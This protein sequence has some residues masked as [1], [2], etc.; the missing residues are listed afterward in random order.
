MVGYEDA[1]RL[2]AALTATD[3]AWPVSDQPA[4]PPAPAARTVP[5]P[6]VVNLPLRR[7]YRALTRALVDAFDTAGT[8]G[9]LVRLSVPLIGVEPLDWLAAQTTKPALYWRDRDGQRRIAGVGVADRLDVGAGD[10]PETA[11]AKAERRL[12]A[13]AADA[14]YFG[15]LR[16]DREAAIGKPWQAF[17]HGW[18]ILPRF[19]IVEEAGRLSLVCN[20][21]PARDRARAL[22]SELDALSDAPRTPAMPTLAR[23]DRDAPSQRGWSDAVHAVTDGIARGEGWRKVVLARR[24]T[25]RCAEAIEPLGMLRSL[26]AGTPRCFHFHFDPGGGSAFLGATPEQ[27]FHRTGSTVHSEALAGTRPRG[28]DAAEDRAL[29]AA[30]VGSL[31][32]G[33]E[34]GFVDTHVRQALAGMTTELTGEEAVS[35]LKL[36]SV[37][38]L[39]RRMHGTLREGCGDA[40]LMQ[41]LHPTPAV[42]GEPPD[43][44]VARIR[45]LEPFDRGWYAGPVG[46]VGRD[47]SRFAVGIRSAVVEGRT[48]ALY[49][50]AGVVEGSQPG[51]EWREL[52]AKL[53]GI[54]TGPMF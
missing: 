28:A 10:A 22:L 15:G 42:C 32:D 2:D 12:A 34:H 17:G 20:L 21:F 51:D 52:E 35:V 1:D 54:W 33:H 37:Q 47:E 9:G 4:L 53:R 49:T 41:A 18:L 39:V 11:V 27:L 40:A 16:F 43:A 31:K 3:T 30:L 23:R 48:V 25:L 36:A 8:S 7:A 26:A 6:G 13:T 14:R 38:H 5:I 50:G 29:E 45:A 44:A 46:Y 24:T 19:E